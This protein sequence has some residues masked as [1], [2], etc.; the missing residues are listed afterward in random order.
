LETLTGIALGK[1][2]SVGQWLRVGYK[3][4]VM[5]VSDIT[6]REVEEIGYPSSIHIFRVREQMCKKHWD[7]RPS[8]WSTYSTSRWDAEVVRQAIE[9]EFKDEL[10]EVDQ[11]GVAYNEA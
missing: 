2:Y 4:L 7:T 10:K 6:L 9:E 3:E 8:S 5:R 11:D 1:K